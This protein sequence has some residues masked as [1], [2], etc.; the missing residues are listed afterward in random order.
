MPVLLNAVVYSDCV[1]GQPIM[2]IPPEL[3]GVSRPVKSA[4]W[5]RYLYWMALHG[6]I[7]C[8]F[9]EYIGA[10]IIAAIKMHAKTAKYFIFMSLFLPFSLLKRYKPIWS[11]VCSAHCLR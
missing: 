2:S 1:R 5:V 11:I 10:T 6:G 9:T 8:A 3:S 7:L 4:S